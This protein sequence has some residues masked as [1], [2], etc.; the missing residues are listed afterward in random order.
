MKS[1]QDFCIIKQIYAQNKLETSKCHVTHVSVLTAQIRQTPDK[2]VHQTTLLLPF[3]NTMP[4]TQRTVYILLAA[5]CNSCQPSPKIVQS[6]SQQAMSALLICRAFIPSALLQDLWTT[7]VGAKQKEQKLSRCCLV[8]LCK[9]ALDDS[10]FGCCSSSSG[11]SR[12][13]VP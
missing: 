4:A 7:H 13:A 12:H 5:L 6:P 3:L 1:C 11:N 2:D 8:S 10:S 9:P